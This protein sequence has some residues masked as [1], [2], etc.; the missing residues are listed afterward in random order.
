VKKYL[1]FFLLSL[2]LEALGFISLQYRIEPFRH[3][4]YVTS[5]WSYIILAD[6][7]LAYRN[8]KFLILNRR[9]PML[10]MISSGYWCIFELLNVRLQNW[11][12]INLPAE[13]CLRYTGYLLSFGTV[14]PAIM[15][16]KEL[17]ITLLP[18][19]K[20]EEAL[21]GGVCIWRSYP[22][23]AIASGVACLAAVIVFPLFTFPLAWVFL[24]LIFDGLN[25]KKGYAS[26]AKEV[27]NRRS[28]G[29]I[30]SAAAG[31]ICGLMWEAWNFNAVAKW[32]YT[33][34]FVQG[35]KLFEMPLPG[36]AGFPA[37]GVETI[38][39]V[40]FLKGI[41]GSKTGIYILSVL[42]LALSFAV[43]VMI[44]R[45]TVLSYDI[46]YR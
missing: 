34:P 40:G 27:W 32:I 16:T 29:L 12:Y 7:V 22:Y 31:R 6:S 2:A 9:L 46:L 10:I 26:F 4:F 19:L 20:P 15:I 17:L 8:H 39:F 21:D 5:W 24:A 35:I 30:G 23:V 14:I 43:F 25:Y 36:Y 44:D 37:F 41:E 33:V 11:H 3:Y 28:A 18:S 13:S 38:A 42:S 45:Y 1:P